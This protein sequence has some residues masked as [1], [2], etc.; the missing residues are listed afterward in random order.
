MEQSRWKSYVL[1]GA[2]AAQMLSM[3]VV[4]GVLTPSQSEVI[5]GLVSAALQCFVA[6]GVLNSPTTKGAL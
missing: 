1:W 3:L 6:F 4:L 2:L 5:N